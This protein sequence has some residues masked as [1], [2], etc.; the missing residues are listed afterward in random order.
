MNILLPIISFLL[1]MA[2]MKIFLDYQ[3]RRNLSKLHEDMSEAFAELS[4]K[5][6]KI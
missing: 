4:I 2:S 6:N 1:G 3:D 5:V